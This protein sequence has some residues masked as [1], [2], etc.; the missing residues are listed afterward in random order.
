M[1]KNSENE[2]YFNW[3]LSQLD[4]VEGGDGL[5][6]EYYNVLWYLFKIEFR[7]SIDKDENRIYDA[8]VFRKDFYGFTGIDADDLGLPACTVLEVLIG[9]SRRLSEDVLGDEDEKNLKKHWFWTWIYNLGLMNYKGKNYN[10]IEVGTRVAVWLNRDFC[11]DGL[12]SPFP[13]VEPPCDQRE[14]EIW[15]QVMLYLAENGE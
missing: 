5:Y 8:V 9:L 15:K 10:E 6:E 12:G 11:Y 14:C 7:Y 13:L 1:R 4:I 3:L 2:Q